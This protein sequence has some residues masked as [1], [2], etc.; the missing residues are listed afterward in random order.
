VLA[1]LLFLPSL[2]LS[3]ERAITTKTFKDQ[4]PMIELFDEE[5]DI[6]LDDLHIAA[7]ETDNAN[8]EELESEPEK[9]EG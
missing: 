3:L 5:V 7:H 9:P 8:G 1:N 4:D 2:L 6:D